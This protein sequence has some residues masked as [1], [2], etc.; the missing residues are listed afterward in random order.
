MT[1]T[2]RI[3]YRADMVACSAFHVGNP[4]ADAPLDARPCRLDSH[5]IPY[6][7]G[8]SIAGRLVE[9]VRGLCPEF[10]IAAPAARQALTSKRDR[11][12]EAILV[13]SRVEVRSAYPVGK[14]GIVS[15]S[16]RGLAPLRARDRVAIDRNLGVAAEHLKYQQIE[17]PCGT[18]FR[19]SLEIDLE[20]WGDASGEGLED[21]VHW[22]ETA[23][24]QWTRF[25][26]V[27]GQTGVGCGWFFL[28]GLRRHAVSAEGLD[29]Y[30]GMGDPRS[31]RE[32]LFEELSA[33]KVDEILARRRDHLPLAFSVGVRAGKRGDGY[34]WDSLLVRG[35][36]YWA[37]KEQFDAVFLRR[38]VQGGSEE[39][40]VP[41][42]SL[43]GACHAYLRRLAAP[44]GSEA[45]Q[46]LLGGPAGTKG[47]RAGVALFGDL[48]PSGEVLKIT[49][50]RHAEDEFRGS[51]LPGALFDERPVFQGVFE[52]HVVCESQDP[53]YRALFRAMRDALDAGVRCDLLGL[54][55]GDS[56]IAWTIGAILEG[57]A[58]RLNRREGG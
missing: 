20:P 8:S 57:D 5:G 3:L 9:T 21:L 31:D 32:E 36:E 55:A 47:G 28:D 11:E 19:V 23:L 10:D 13:A 24:A 52:G 29:D 33:W 12:R 26:R 37:H 4:D 45:L 17:V 43:K 49:V 34:G 14:S 46:F 1:R 53:T 15:G 6:V 38:E 44:P 22:V 2:L 30:L 7:P 40:Y 56:R 54:G 50:H 25:G 16:A 42:S 58:F 18:R 41:G 35:G 51:V 39:C 27:G 48:A